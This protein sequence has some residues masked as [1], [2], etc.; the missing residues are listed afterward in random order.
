MHDKNAGDVVLRRLAEWGVPGGA[1]DSQP[2]PATF[3]LASRASAWACV[4]SCV[5]VNIAPTIVY[6]QCPRPARARWPG[7]GD[8][9]PGPDGEEGDDAGLGLAEVVPGHGLS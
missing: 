4:A 3:A 8:V 5:C 1:L 7:G 6:C 9:L 2:R